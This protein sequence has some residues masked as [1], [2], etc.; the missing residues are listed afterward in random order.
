ME[1]FWWE[2]D[3]PYGQLAGSETLKP[4]QALLF[5]CVKASAAAA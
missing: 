4:S 1:A 3:R 5:F 2:L